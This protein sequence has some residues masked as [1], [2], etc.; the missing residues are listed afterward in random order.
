MGAQGIVVAIDGPSGAGKGR[1]ARG[2]AERLGYLYIDTG[3]MYR[4]VALVAREQ[5]ISLE[6][7]EAVAAL[8]VRLRLDFARATEGIHIFADGRDV[9]EAIRSPE[10]SQAASRVA[11]FPDVRRHLVA[12]QQRIG[13][14]GGIVMEGRDIGTV[15]FPHAELKIFLDASKEERARRR[16][17]QQLEQGHESSLEETRREIEQRDRRDSERAAS[18]LIRADD[19][20]YLDTTALSA[21]EAVEVIVRLA[22]TR[23]GK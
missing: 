22:R 17:L 1:V 19:A 8:A 3:A 5:G 4:A 6:D 2:V 10:A 15:V 9:T 7:A 14:A 20:V 21:Y 13:A 18:P 23:E 12:Q 16:H 11:I